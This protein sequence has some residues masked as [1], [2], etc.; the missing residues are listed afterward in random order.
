MHRIRTYF[1]GPW[2]LFALAASLAAFSCAGADAPPAAPPVAGEAQIKA[3]F[4]YNFIKFVEWPPKRFAAGDR[5][6]EVG[7]LGADGIAD[8]FE[9]DVRGR[10]AHSRRIRVSRISSPAEAKASDVV[11]IGAQ[12]D[13]R[14]AEILGAVRGSPVLT[15]G[16]SERFASLGGIITF[17]L[18]K[19]SVRFEINSG[20]GDRSGLRI[21][22]QLLKLATLIRKDNATP[23]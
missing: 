14:A 10:S 8:E 21:S 2:R 11:F 16:E 18:S 22:F 15:V 5:P 19:G 6:I 23:P 9:A 12:A 7:I 4:L 3:A 20:E 17:T 13:P 1:R